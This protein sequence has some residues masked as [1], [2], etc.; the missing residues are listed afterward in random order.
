VC[1]KSILV[2]DDDASILETLDFVLTSDGYNVFIANNG[3]DGLSILQS[4][5]ID[6][7]VLD[8]KMPHLSGYLFATIAL[9]HTQNKNVKILV[10]TGESLMAGNCE[11]TVANA[12][13]KLTKPFEINTLRAAVAQLVKAPDSYLL[14]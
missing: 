14:Y 3:E 8:L 4:N 12:T 9:K 5:W 2:I 11:L 1:P 10:L 7:I 13:Q 6:G